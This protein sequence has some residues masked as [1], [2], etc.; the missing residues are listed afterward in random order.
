M[1]SFLI[2][3]KTRIDLFPKAFG[4]LL[5]NL[6]DCPEEYE[7]I[8][9]NDNKKDEN[10]QVAEALER[11]GVRFIYGDG[12][13]IAHAYNAAAVVAKGDKLVFVNDDIVFFQPFI[14]PFLETYD[15]GYHIVGVK[16]LYPNLTIQHAG[17][18]FYPEFDWAATHVYRG[19]DRND[20]LVNEF[21]EYPTVTY[22]LVMINA[23]LY[24][25]LNGISLDYQGNYE[26]TDFS[27]RALQLGV[28]IAYD[29]R[30]EAIHYDASTRGHNLETN[31][32]AWNTFKDKWLKD[33]KLQNLLLEKGFIDE[34]RQPIL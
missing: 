8:I 20:P 22:S 3:T 1:I 12:L 7:I 26:D 25:Q 18:I 27:L 34:S 17:A 4:S 11:M 23:C 33:D 9:V 28:K 13:G 15:K 29:P 21:K 32:K 10:T 30:V 2:P 5:F 24:K 14:L 19:I 31:T 6:A 16:L